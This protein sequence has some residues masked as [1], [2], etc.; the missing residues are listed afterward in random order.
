MT[1][2][3]RVVGGEGIVHFLI[4]VHITEKERAE[5][6]MLMA[7]IKLQ[8]Q[9]RFGSGNFFVTVKTNSDALKPKHLNITIFHRGNSYS[10][11]SG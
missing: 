4:F 9:A 2:C 6:K 10:C 3:L 8:E 5:S 11:C 1:V 7:Q